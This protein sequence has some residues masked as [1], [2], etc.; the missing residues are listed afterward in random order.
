V[1]FRKKLGGFY[2][3]DQLSETYNLPD[4]TFEKIKK[5]LLVNNKAIKKININ[6]STV[7]ELKA[8]PYISYAVANAIFQY[9]QQHGKF[10]SIDDLK[11][12]MSIDDQLLE[13]IAPYLSIE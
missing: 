3:L 2:S 10:N 11:K 5:Y 6:S 4:S 7:D 1:A 12:I 13:K 9:R 8:H